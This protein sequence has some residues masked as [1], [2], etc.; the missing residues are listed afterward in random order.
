MPGASTMRC[1]CGFVVMALGSTSLAAAADLPAYMQPIAGHGHD[2]AGRDRDQ[3]RAGAQHRHVRALRRRRPRLPEEHPGQASGHPRPVLRAPA[4]ASSSI[5][6]GMPPLEAPPV[7]LVYQLMKS[8]GP[9]HD[10]AD[11]G[12]EAL[13]RQS[14]RTS[15]G[16]A[17]MLAYR[18]R[19]QSA[20]EAL[21]ATDMQADWRPNSRAHPAEQ[22]RLH[23]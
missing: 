18:S 10:G 7:P 5:G 16:A 23:G 8:V 3:E 4:G 13:P 1:V 2:D 6:P 22:H 15:P 21:D 14:R 17:P 20:L 12:G 19:M 9:Q 11:R